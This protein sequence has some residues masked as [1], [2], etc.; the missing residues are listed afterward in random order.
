MV[1]EEETKNTLPT[2][3]NDDA[4]QEQ[5]KAES[6]HSSDETQHSRGAGLLA[7]P[8]GSTKA[9]FNGGDPMQKSSRI[10]RI[11]R[12]SED[13]DLR[14]ARSAHGPQPVGPDDEEEEED[15]EGEVVP[16]SWRDVG[17]ACCCHSVTEWLSIG[18]SLTALCFFLYFFLLGLELMGTS[19]KVVGGCTAGSLL[20]SDVNPL[21]S[22]I[23]GIIATA[24][25]QSS[26]TTASIIVS[27]VSGGLDVHQ[28]MC[29]KRKK[30]LKWL[31]LFV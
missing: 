22:L 8:A 7:S 2:I 4:P 25:L 30:Y 23:I 12:W 29:C 6:V 13:G 26:S 20:G 9:L 28:G 19:F 5:E 11:F 21:S 24:L 3:N 18:G 17:T 10:G 14:P 1:E 27:L 31:F 15:Q 16:A